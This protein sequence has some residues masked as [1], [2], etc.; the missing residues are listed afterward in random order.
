MIMDNAAEMQAET[1]ADNYF[2]L[3]TSEDATRIDRPAL[4]LNGELSPRL[5]HLIIDELARCLPRATKTVIPDAS[6]VIHVGN[7]T[8]YNNGARLSCEAMTVADALI[9][10]SR[11]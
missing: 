3:F 11:W 10:Q 2:P 8:A 9:A 1:L 7:P 4:L 6:H 5:F